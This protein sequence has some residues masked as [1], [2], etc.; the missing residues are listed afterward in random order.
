MPAPSRRWLF[1]LLL[2][3]VAAGFVCYGVRSRSGPGFADRFGLQRELA[4][5]DRND[6][7]LERRRQIGLNRNLAKDKVVREVLAG[8]LTLA[9]AAV[10]F[11]NVEEESP[12]TWG[13]LRIAGWTGEDERLCRDVTER[14][15]NWLAENLPE[16]VAQIDARLKAE[17]QQLRGPD[18]VVR[19]PD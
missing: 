13:P 16:V 9:E 15:H 17:L 4:A 6:T 7:E 14:A 10:C 3:V 2:A 19:L 1:V 11:R 18:G 12:M 5:R 8:R